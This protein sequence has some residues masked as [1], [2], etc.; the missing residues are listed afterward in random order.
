MF[1]M[2]GQWSENKVSRST[3]NYLTLS[4]RS[5]SCSYDVIYCARTITMVTGIFPNM[6]INFSSI[7]YF[8]VVDLIIQ[9]SARCLPL[10]LVFLF[11]IYL[12]VKQLLSVWR[13]LSVGKK[14]FE[15]NII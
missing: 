9:R 2:V 11:C 8:K 5:V 12:C 4:K 3:W 7:E 13:V 6:I 10:V 1:A 14:S 15:S